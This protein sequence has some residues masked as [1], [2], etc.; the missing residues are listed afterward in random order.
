MIGSPARAALVLDDLLTDPHGREVLA[1]LR[2]HV[3]TAV[4]DQDQAAAADA[5]RLLRFEAPFIGGE[6]T[7]TA[8]ADVPDWVRLPMLETYLGWCAGKARTC[9]HSPAPDRPEPVFATAWQPG[10]VVCSRCVQLT[11][12]RPGSRRDR[13]CDRCGRVVAGIEHGDGI[14]AGRLQY[15]PLLYAWG[16]CSD[17]LPDDLGHDR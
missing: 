4:A 1:E 11:V 13:T 7:E 15:G 17:C 9:L 8:H 16:A 12:L 6:V 10:L 2:R 5:L 14:F 3:P